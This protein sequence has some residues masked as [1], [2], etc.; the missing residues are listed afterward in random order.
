M[1]KLN[2]FF[3][4]LRA[5]L[6]HLFVRGVPPKQGKKILFISNSNIPTLQLSFLKPLAAVVANGKYSYEIITEQN[7]KDLFSKKVG[8]KEAEGYFIDRARKSQADIAIFCR[9]SGPHG[10]ALLKFFTENSIPSIYHIDDDLLN[11]PLEL[12]K[13]KYEYHNH[14]ARKEAVR[15]LLSGIDLIY[16]SNQRLTQRLKK[17]GIQKDFY[18][19]DIYASGSIINK[20]EI[21]P[22]RKIGYMGIDHAHDLEMIVPALEKILDQFGDISFELFGPIPKPQALDRFGSRVVLIPPVSG[23]GDFM[24]KFSQLHWDI[25]LCPLASIP[26]N[27][28]KSN[29]KWVEYSSVGAAVIA[30]KGTIYDECC[31]NEAGI[32][33]EDHE[34]YSN[35]KLLIEDDGLR[36]KLL[37]NAQEK[38]ASSFTEEH[39]FSQIERAIQLA[40]AQV[41]RR[42]NPS[43]GGSV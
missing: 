14:P 17:Y 39:L 40:S 15:H 8:D 13:K 22:V 23:Y 3:R 33:S 4:K 2:V 25:A 27:M 19:G 37:S 16:C 38:I 11:I 6:N 10:A 31:A 7:L 5:R 1:N 21:R 29:T 32:L 9:Y 41:A 20:P 12:G 35:I 26:F 24:N 36:F 18:S 34:W 30:S 42:H 43:I 28:V